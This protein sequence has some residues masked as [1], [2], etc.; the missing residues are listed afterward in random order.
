MYNPSIQ[1]EKMIEFSRW[2]VSL[3]ALRRAVS[4]EGI[5][6]FRAWTVLT[7]TN[8]CLPKSIVDNTIVHARRL[9][10][11]SEM[12]ANTYTWQRQA[13]R[14]LVMAHHTRCAILL[15]PASKSERILTTRINGCKQRRDSIDQSLNQDPRA[16][17]FYRTKQ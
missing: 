14:Q 8:R 3:F 4:K 17:I 16:A 13:C 1:T 6:T 12:H 2:C 7:S 11:P 9:W 5:D 10:C 15:R